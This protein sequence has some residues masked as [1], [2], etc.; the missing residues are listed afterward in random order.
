MI[1]LRWAANDAMR[2]FDDSRAHFSVEPIVNRVVPAVRLS[3]LYIV[4]NVVQ[5]LKGH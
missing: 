5:R 1:N 4:E 2:W 3:A